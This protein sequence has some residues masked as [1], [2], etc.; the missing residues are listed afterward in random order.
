MDRNK[1][2]IS[3]TE[4]IDAISNTIYKKCPSTASHSIR[5]RHICQR[6]GL[7]MDLNEEEINKLKICGLLHDVGKVA[8]DDNILKKTEEL[9]ELEWAEIKSHSDIGFRIL[10]AYPDMADIARCVL[11][12][13]E[14][15][16]GKGYPRGIAKEEIPFISRVIAVADAYD[17]MTSQRVYK[18]ALS[19]NQALIELEKN[20]GT[21][22]DPDIVDVFI[23]MS[24]MM[25]KGI[26]N[27]TQIG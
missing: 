21:Q 27:I 2:Q 5:V 15:F 20:K 24:D 16:D 7:A 8:V 3:I 9:T 23:K 4:I 12:H 18:K 17:A 1:Q 26:D 11:Y 13:H 22:F 6:I 10:N 14:R 19:K 25:Q